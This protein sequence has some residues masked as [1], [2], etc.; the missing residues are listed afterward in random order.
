M[1]TRGAGLHPSAKIKWLDDRLPFTRLLY[2]SFVAYQGA[3]V[4]E[5]DR[6]SKEYRF[7]TV[8]GRQE[9]QAIQRRLRRA[10]GQYLRSVGHTVESAPDERVA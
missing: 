10:V 6:M 8:D 2:D 9:A 1:R 4:S 7:V 3:L 5:F